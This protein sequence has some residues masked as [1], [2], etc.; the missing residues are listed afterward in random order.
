MRVKT[1]QETTLASRD[2]LEMTEG[3]GDLTFMQNQFSVSNASEP[4]YVP[5]T[6]RVPGHD[7]R[8]FSRG[9]V[10]N[11][12]SPNAGGFSPGLANT[13][14]PSPNDQPDYRRMVSS[15]NVSQR[16]EKEE[17]QDIFSELM[18]G[19][20]HEVAFLTRHFAQVIAPWYVLSAMA[21]FRL[22]IIDLGWIFLMQGSSSRSWYRLEQSTASI[23]NTQLQ[24]WR[25]NNSGE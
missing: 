9:A 25:Q 4:Q 19:T 17:F 14:K 6:N 2:D 8:T 22:L 3:P 12:V 1:S 13:T 21:L 16:S 5:Q 24:L 23:S 18:T 7:S 11:S 15:E 20:E 10:Q